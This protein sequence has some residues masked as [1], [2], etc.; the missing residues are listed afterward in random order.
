MDF[1]DLLKSAG[2]NDSIGELVGGGDGFGL[3][4]VLG[5]ARKFF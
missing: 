4:D 3:D 5:M 2:G 1:L